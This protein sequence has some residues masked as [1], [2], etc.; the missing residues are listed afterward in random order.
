MVYQPIVR[1][2]ARATYAHEALVRTS[3]VTVPHPGALLDL[4]E[5]LD[6]LPQLGHRIRGLVAEPLDRA[7]ADSLLF[8]NL[9][10]HDLCDERLF[11]PESPLAKMAHRVVLEITE[12]ANLDCI[13]DPVGRISRL[14]RLGFRIA[15]D[16]IGA[17]YAGLNSIVTLAP[18]IVKLD[19]TLVRGIDGDGLKQK[20]VGALIELCAGMSVDLI[21]EGV[22][23]HAELQTL[24]T[25]GCDLFQG[26]LF[27]R[28]APPFITADWPTGLDLP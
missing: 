8:V 18:D 6:S 26:Y 7:P 2:S 21:A 1:W 27:A 24:L 16:D 4:A 12:R 28:P 13:D 17:G 5:R 22:E 14:K 3:E 23:T 9:H 19:M 10:S 25:L 11:D 20:L 15:V